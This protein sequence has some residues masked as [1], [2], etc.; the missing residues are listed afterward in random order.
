MLEQS[1]NSALERVRKKLWPDTR[2]YLR[3]SAER[4]SKTTEEFSQDNY[5]LDFDTRRAGVFGKSICQGISNTKPHL[6]IKLIR[7]SP[8]P[9]DALSPH[10][11]LDYGDT[12]LHF[13]FDT[14]PFVRL[15]KKF[16]C[17]M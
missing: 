8:L 12:R 9:G 10:T 13:S 4:L 5:R 3:I 6:A 17:K 16:R 11:G 7:D 2:H 15:Y 14:E 1:V